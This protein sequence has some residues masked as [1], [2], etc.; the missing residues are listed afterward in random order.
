MMDNGLLPSITRPTRITQQSATLIDN[1]FISPILQ[2]NFDSTIIINDISDHLPTLTM[3]KQTRVSDK[4]AIEFHSRKLNDNKIHQINDEIHAVDWNGVLNSK[5]CNNNFNK[6]C[7]ILHEAMDKIA[8]LQCIK[9]SGKRHYTE[10]WM[11]T[12]IETST[13]KNLKLYKKILMKNCTTEDINKY[14][15][16]RNPL[17]RI[18]R[19]AKCMYYI[20]KCHEYKSNTRK[21]WEVINQTIV[22]HK[23]G[24]S[25]IPC[26]SIDSIKTYNT[27]K[28][29]NTFGSFHVNLGS[30][31]NQERSQLKSILTPFLIP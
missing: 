1:I 3:M 4:N 26:I 28:I 25:L 23:H 2:H 19:H 13:H 15:V 7:D 27:K 8:P 11:T 24:G 5:D 10:P 6:F 12:G 20:T 30:N 21:L 16:H 18:K 14:K 22:K 29:S 17:N 9:I 31:S